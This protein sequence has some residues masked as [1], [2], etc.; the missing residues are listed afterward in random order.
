[1]KVRAPW[2]KEFLIFDNESEGTITYILPNQQHV[3]LGG[4]AYE[5]DTNTQV[6]DKDVQHIL[7]SCCEIMPS[8]KEAQH[9]CHW[10]GIR[11]GRS[12]V[13]LER[14]DILVE[15]KVL[16]VVHNYGHGGGGLTLHRG[17]ALDAL[18]LVSECVNEI[19][20]STCKL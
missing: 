8:L 18:K 1:M 6:D 9:I 7:Q 2:V 17:C 15:N 3:V 11:P 5:N 12:S 14:E 4:T 13:R 19:E 20:T 16:R 10:V